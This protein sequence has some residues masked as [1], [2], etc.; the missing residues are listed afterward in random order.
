MASGQ[1]ALDQAK[2]TELIGKLESGN[3][4]I[5]QAFKKQQEAVAV[6]DSSLYDNRYSLNAQEPWDQEKFADLL[7]RWIVAT[8]QPFSIV[9]DVELREL[10]IYTHHPSPS[11]KIPQRD[12]IKRRIMKMG[13]DAITATRHM[14]VV[15]QFYIF[16]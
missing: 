15:H 6:W 10:L 13:E 7:G 3:Q 14:F 2:I 1:K 9:D 8:N 5:Q 11:L 4:T 12:A 16:G